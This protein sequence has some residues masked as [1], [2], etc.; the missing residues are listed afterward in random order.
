MTELRGD[1]C[2]SDG[3][4]HCI[5]CGDEGIPM[6]VTELRDGSA[7]CADHDQARHQIAIDLVEPVAIGDELLVHAG[8]A[9]GHLGTLR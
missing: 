6:R 9:I 4:E 2:R 5:T 8:V 1:A 3:E 7:V